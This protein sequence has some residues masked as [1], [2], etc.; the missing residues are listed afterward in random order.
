MIFTS[1]GSSFECRFTKRE[2]LVVVIKG[3]VRMYTQNHGVY[4]RVCLIRVYMHSDRV[5]YL[6]LLVVLNNHIL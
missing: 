2:Y 6:T 1:D 5:T 4:T 3:Q